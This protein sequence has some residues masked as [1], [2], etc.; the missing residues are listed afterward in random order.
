MK[1]ISFPPMICGAFLALSACSNLNEAGIFTQPDEETLVE[2]A[3]EVE[4][5]G[6]AEVVETVE[7][8]PPP[9]PPPTAET[10]EQF[11][12][13]DAEDRAEALDVEV[14]AGERD[15]GVTL[16]TLGAPTD[17]G[18]WVKTP[19]VSEVIEGRVEYQGNSINVELR[20]SGGEPGSGSQI[21]LPAMRLLNAPLTGIVELA[22]F[23]P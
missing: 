16:A 7:E 22:V 6:E 9:P 23:V 5:E 19:L 4:P 18:I 8:T 12:T 14:V 17:P 21:S 10:V 20:P 3:A 2:V 11:D 1:Q 15:L 13:T